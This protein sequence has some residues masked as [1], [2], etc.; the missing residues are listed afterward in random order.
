M[1]REWM[2]RKMTGERLG[3]KKTEYDE[4]RWRWD[5]G[6]EKNGVKT[7][8]ETRRKDSE[9][10]MQNAVMTERVVP[11]CSWSQKRNKR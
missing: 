4:G 5:S 11:E 1:K 8:R 9:G 6:E 3:G 2:K 7:E 10:E